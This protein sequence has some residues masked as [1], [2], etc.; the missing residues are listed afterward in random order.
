[1]RKSVLVDV[2]GMLSE[3]LGSRCEIAARLSQHCTDTQALMLCVPLW[4]RAA[5]VMELGPVGIADGLD[6]S[7]APSDDQID[8][9]H[10]LPPAQSQ[11][12]PLG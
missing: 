7:A 9:G 8:L 12:M 10:V 4:A 5:H 1:M 3:D 2:L 6:Q 11:Y